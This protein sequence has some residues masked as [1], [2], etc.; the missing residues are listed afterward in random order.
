MKLL[1]SKKTRAYMLLTPLVL[2][3]VVFFLWPLLVMMKQSISDD[4]VS[5]VLKETASVI[6]EWDEKSP[7]TAAMQQ[8]FIKDIQ[9]EQDPQAI[10][11]MIRKLNSEQAGFRTLLTKTSSKING[12]PTVTDLVSID[13]RW[14][15]PKYWQAINKLL[16]PVT[17]RYLLA[18]VDMNRD[19]KGDIQ[20]MPASQ[21]ANLD[22]MLRTFWIAALVT[23]ICVLIG[24]PYA[25]L[26]ASSE[27]WV[28]NVLFM[29]VLLPLWTSLLVRTAA[30]FILLQDQGLINDAL[31][32]IGLIDQPLHLIFNRVGVVIS[33]THVLLP[34]MV[35]PIYSV[36]K[37]IPGNLMPAASSLGAAPWKAFLRVLLPLSF[38]GILSGMLLVFMTSIGYYITP[39]LIGGAGDQMISSIIA[40]YAT[41]AAN[42][43]MAGALGVIL[44]VVCL[45]LF[46]VYERI[47]TDN[48]RSA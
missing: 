45:V 40:Y 23:L 47:T 18:A 44:L 22:I 35:L 43:G 36:L 21:S 8:A 11:N 20:K 41:G 31:K 25:I 10:G 39:A 7:P 42:W 29:A 1:N 28:K 14:S 5:S 26:L 2:F 19:L 13:S 48:T 30:W 6:H 24:Y 15:D 37:T 9:T 33:M 38:R 3:V 46:T 17:D 4:A 34:F 16:S 27:G 32:A 12:T